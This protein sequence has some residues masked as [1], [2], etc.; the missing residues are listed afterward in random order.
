MS[1][2]TVIVGASAAGVSTA[3]ALQRLEPSREIILVGD[4][5]TLAHDRPP[6]SKQV[7][8]GT[9]TP[10][11]AQLL[12][13]ARREALRAELLLGK[14]AAGVDIRAR[15]LSIDDG[16]QLSYDDLVIATG[17][18]PREL[19]APRPNGVHV[20]RT[21]SE[22]QALRAHLT[23]AKGGPLVIVGG[24][25]IG[26][27]V[28]ATARKLGIAVTLVEPAPQALGRRIGAQAASRLME[29]HR[30]QEVQFRLGTG[31]SGFAAD[32]HGKVTAVLLADGSALEARVVL[33]AIGC[34]PNVEWLAGSGLDI[35]DGVVCDEYCRAAPG[36]W[37]AGDVARWRHLASDR[38]MRIEHR[39]NATEQGSAVAANIIGPLQPYLPTP[40]FWTDQYAVKLQLAGTVS[41]DAEETVEH[42]GG[43]SYLHTYRADGRLVAVLGWNA[44]RA[45]M[46]L[47]KELGI[48]ARA[49]QPPAPVAA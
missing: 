32:S 34:V 4:E 13:P 20:L 17:V 23:E 2:R 22:C 29:R 28:A 44:A 33:V 24:G 1:K 40:F 45:M 9:W 3:E 43:D 35:S 21:I 18:R 15:R 46:P 31:V 39:L 5:S 8:E 26:L 27:E 12:P 14:R 10:D 47:R 16:T 11:Q 19:H 6:L 7:L 49:V 30:E 25:F 42:Q 38:H 37:A 41:P 36:V 48:A